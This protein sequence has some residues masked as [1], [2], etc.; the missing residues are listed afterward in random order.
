MRPI[1]QIKV[2]DYVMNKDHDSTNKVVFVE[3]H[4]QVQYS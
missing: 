2:G 1:S 4:A 3:T